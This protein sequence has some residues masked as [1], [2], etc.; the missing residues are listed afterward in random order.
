MLITVGL[1]QSSTSIV[2]SSTETNAVDEVD[3]D[4]EETSQVDPMLSLH[5]S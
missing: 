2:S 3:Q 5:E 4:T 1:S